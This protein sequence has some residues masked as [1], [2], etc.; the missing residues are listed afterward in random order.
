LPYVVTSRRADFVLRIYQ[1]WIS[2]PLHALTNA[3]GIVPAG[4]RFQPT[5]SMYAREAITKYGLLRGGWMTSRRLARCHPFSRGER[6][7]SFDPVP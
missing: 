6:S 3:F 5:C 7:G 2:P 1:R 4:C